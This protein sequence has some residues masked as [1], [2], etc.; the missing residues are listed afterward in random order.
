VVK[1][2]PKNGVAESDF[3]FG[4]PEVV[5]CPPGIRTVAP[6]L[7]G[8]G[9]RRERFARGTKE[10]GMSWTKL[11]VTGLVVVAALIFWMS[12]QIWFAAFLG[13]LLAISLNGPAMWIRQYVTMPAWLSTLLV[14]LVMLMALTGLGWIIGAPLTSQVQDMITKLPDSTERAVVWLNDRAWG[15]NILRQA[16]KWSGMTQDEMKNADGYFARGA[17]H[18]EQWWGIYP[19]VHPPADA[20]PPDQDD[21]EADDQKDAADEEDAA[22]E[23][24]E[25]STLFKPIRAIVTGTIH[26]GA[27]LAVSLAM[28]LFVALDPHVYQRGVLWLVPREHDEVARTTMRRLGTAMRWWMLGRLASMAAI[29]VLTSLGMWA[30]GMPAP[31]A[32]GALAGLLSF[33]PNIGPIIAAIPGMILALALGPWMIL[34]AL[35]V[36]VAAQLIESNAVSPLVDQYT[37]SVPPGVVIVTQFVLAILAGVWGMIIATPLL[38]VIIVLIQQLYIREGLNEPI[39][40]IGTRTPA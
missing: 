16:G 38:V 4:M 19:N 13:V 2:H 14:M 20:P 8:S 31:M 26:I 37:V 36:Y 35:C 30:I 28:M 32:L 21:D 24:L 40:V 25:V 10:R 29:G 34:G 23:D 17:E 27:L 6:T 18:P 39:R 33:V 3:D 7:S 11:A 12:Y 1:R 15:K 22:P 5:V 9:R